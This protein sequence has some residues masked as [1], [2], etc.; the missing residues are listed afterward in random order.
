MARKFGKTNHVKID[1]LAYNIALLGEPKIGKTTLIYEV[2]KKLA[3]DDGYIFLEMGKEDGA[4]AIEGIVYE[5]VPDWDYFEEIVDDIVDNKESDYPDLKVAVIDTYDGFID[6]AE[7]ET[8]RRSN[9]A[10]QGKKDFKKANTINEAWG[11]F[12]KGQQKCLE[13]MLDALWRL[14][15]VGVSFIV[16][17]HV[18]QKDKTDIWTGETYSILTNDVE[19]RYFTG[20]MKKLHVCGLAYK[21]RTVET[22]KTGK[23][24]IVTGK[25]ETKNIVKGE[26]R[27]INFRDTNYVADNGGR[28]AN[29]IEEI[30]FGA[31]NFI[32]AITD[33]IKAEQA[34]SGVSF[35]EAQKKEAKEKEKAKKL[36]AEKEKEEKT[37]KL[38]EDGRKKIIEYVMNN[39]GNPEALAK[40][41]NLTSKW[42]VNP[43]V[44]GS[45]TLDQVK[46]VLKAIK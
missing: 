14:K 35:E 10:N 27:R 17:G 46:E 24:N 36:V 20:L 44:E 22:V 21:D 1:P 23:K 45:M 11:G 38:T 40:V 9:K 43:V 37:K 41:T 33:A 12:Q 7:P 28:F 19:Q 3:G 8:I 6:I 16:I 32:N 15:S 29:I 42:G 18:K 26:N 30:E 4:S 34:K 31:D 5:N 2:V 25:E 39:K 13:M